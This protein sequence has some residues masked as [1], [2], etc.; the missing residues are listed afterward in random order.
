MLTYGLTQENL[1]YADVLIFKVQTILTEQSPMAGT[2]H[3]SNLMAQPLN[4]ILTSPNFL[5]HREIH[6]IDCR[7]TVSHRW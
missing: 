5:H 7:S 3:F 1:N 6:R 2:F 4:E